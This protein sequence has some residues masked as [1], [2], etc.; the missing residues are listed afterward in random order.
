M[1][2]ATP[3]VDIFLFKL[4]KN[5]NKIAQQNFTTRKQGHR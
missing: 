1:S 3:N 5:C 2:N 4:I